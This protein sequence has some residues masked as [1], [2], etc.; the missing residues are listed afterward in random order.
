M[1]YFEYFSNI[2]YITNNNDLLYIYI[3]NLFI[4][5]LSILLPKTYE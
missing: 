4:I 2:L 5:N 3:H 1:K